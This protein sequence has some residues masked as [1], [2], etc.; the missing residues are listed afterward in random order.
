MTP[1]ERG[2]FVTP[3][4]T[5]ALPFNR[6]LV[7]PFFS[8][9]FVA[10]SFPAQALSLPWGPRLGHGH[11]EGAPAALCPQGATLLSSVLFRVFMSHLFPGTFQRPIYESHISFTQ[12]SLSSGAPKSGVPGTPHDTEPVVGVR[13]RR[14]QKRPWAPCC[15]AGGGGTTWKRRGGLRRCLGSTHHRRLGAQPRGQREWKL[16]TWVLQCQARG[17][18]DDERP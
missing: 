12:Q 8:S 6:F 5:H 16:G 1:G 9:L 3:T 15:A 2:A 18:T 17:R 10:L 14:P 11:L 4:R 13:G 7:P